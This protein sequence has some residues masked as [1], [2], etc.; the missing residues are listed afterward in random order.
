MLIFLDI[1]G[2]LVPAKSWKS[3]E[4][5]DDGFPAF[6]EDAT[7]ALRQLISNDVTVLLTTSHKSNFT[8][9]EWKSIFKKR[10]IEIPRL[11]T[12]PENK[13]MISRKDELV[14]WFNQHPNEEDF[15]IIDDDSSLNDLP[16]NLK[17]YLIQPSPLIGF[18]EKHLRAFNFMITTK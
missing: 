18:N 16:S 7:K 2:V 8:I 1:D 14:R 13:T 6:S 3:P 4:M 17:K 11:R 15:L 10:G 5:L 9:Q 12:L